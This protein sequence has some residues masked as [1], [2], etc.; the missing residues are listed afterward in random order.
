MKIQSKMK[1]EE[2][3]SLRL[4]EDNSNSLQLASP[5]QRQVSAHT[6]LNLNSNYPTGQNQEQQQRDRPTRQSLEFSSETTT[7]DFGGGGG[8]SRS[9]MKHLKKIDVF[10]QNRKNHLFKSVKFWTTLS[11]VPSCLALAALWTIRT[12]YLTIFGLIQFGGF[13]VAVVFIANNNFLQTKKEQTAYRHSVRYRLGFLLK[14][15][16]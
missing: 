1:E 14:R 13:K 3:E 2:E 6:R 12:P 15:A 8:D 7:T 9:V 4:L 5:M 16:S 11:D 10:S